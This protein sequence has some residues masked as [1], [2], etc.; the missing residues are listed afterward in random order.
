M[1]E[2]EDDVDYSDGTL[3]SPAGPLEPAPSPSFRV[4]PLRVAE[5]VTGSKYRDHLSSRH[6]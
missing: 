5:P 2:N 1:Y 6:V 4:T 3:Y